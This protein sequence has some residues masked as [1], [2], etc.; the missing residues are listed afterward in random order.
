MTEVVKNVIQSAE[1]TLFIH[2]MLVVNTYIYILMTTESSLAK[3]T[4]FKMLTQL[5]LVPMA[6]CN[7]IDD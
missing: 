6:S 2:L 1:T 5:L 3:R 7:N 4:N